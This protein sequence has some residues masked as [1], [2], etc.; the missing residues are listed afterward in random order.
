MTNEIERRLFANLHRVKQYPADLR[1]AL[2]EAERDI[3][4]SPATKHSA[5]EQNLEKGNRK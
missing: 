4:K 5:K 1:D 2:P 3:L